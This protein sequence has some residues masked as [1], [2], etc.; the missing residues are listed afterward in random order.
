MTLDANTKSAL[1]ERLSFYRELGVG[2][3]YRRDVSPVRQLLEVTSEEA[4]RVEAAVEAVEQSAFVATADGSVDRATLL[5]VIADDIGPDCQ[6][7]KLAKLGR[8]QIVFGT[9]DP[10]EIGRAS[11]RERV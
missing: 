1:R 3:L 8:K 6:R 2:P 5:Q 9:G 7:C 10:H 11:C 4:A